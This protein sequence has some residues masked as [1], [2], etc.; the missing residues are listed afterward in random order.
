M[1][2]LKRKSRNINTQVYRI[3][4]SLA[5]GALF[6]YTQSE[7]S[8]QPYYD[9]RHWYHYQATTYNPSEALNSI[10]SCYTVGKWHQLGKCFHFLPLIIMTTIFSIHD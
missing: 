9:G 3:G 6:L 4:T 1:F 5:L 7:G 2:R 8:S 10:E